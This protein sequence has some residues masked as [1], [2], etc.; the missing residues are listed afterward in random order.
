MIKSQCSE[1]TKIFEIAPSSSSES[2]VSQS[3]YLPLMKSAFTNLSAETQFLIKLYL[4]MFSLVAGIASVFSLLQ[5]YSI[6][7][8]L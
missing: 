7:V 2:T 5:L 4:G 8:T 1:T 3:H 6:S